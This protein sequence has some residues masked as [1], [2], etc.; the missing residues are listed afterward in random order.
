MI[1][2]S[3]L[4]KYRANT[5]PEEKSNTIRNSENLGESVKFS[6]QNIL[7]FLP[8]IENYFNDPVLGVNI[9]SLCKQYPTLFFSLKEDYVWTP[10]GLVGMLQ[11]IEEMKKILDGHLQRII[12]EGAH[13]GE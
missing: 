12:D 1:L 8:K 7:R 6:I 9:S 13:K 5:T 4:K 11:S 2:E 3:W 10:E